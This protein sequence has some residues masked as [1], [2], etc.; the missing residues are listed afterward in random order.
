MDRN[1][2]LDWART[3]RTFVL[4]QVVLHKLDTACKD[5]PTKSDDQLDKKPESRVTTVLRQRRL[6]NAAASPKADTEELEP[7]KPTAIKR[8][9]QCMGLNVAC[10]VALQFI[11][12][13]IMRLIAYLSPFS[14]PENW[15]AEFVSSAAGVISILPIFLIT[16]L[17]NALWFSDIA[18]ASLKYRGLQ[19]AVPISFSRAAAD[20]VVAIVV[21]VVFLMQSLMMVYLPIPLIAPFITFFHL[22]LLHALYSFEYFWM[23]Q[24]FE[25][26]SRLAKKC[27]N[28]ECYGF[29][30]GLCGCPAVYS[31][32]HNA[33]YCLQ[34]ENWTTEFVS[35]AAGV[36]SILPIFLITRLVNALWFSDIA[37]ASLKYR[38]LQPAVPISF[39]FGF[40]FICAS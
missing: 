10:V 28:V 2:R 21:E 7:Q 18:N 37:N 32:A 33:A 30:R 15:T 16:R 9:L 27:F 26:K 29:E 36:I 25:L 14:L 8:V 5:A 13:P 31:A 17:V 19:P 1:F 39:R 20:F 4:L 24:G 34:P 40:T 6:A 35:S 23:S 38:G 11:L 12:L 22:S 3:L